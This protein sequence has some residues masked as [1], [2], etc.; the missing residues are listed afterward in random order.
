[1]CVL[2]ANEAQTFDLRAPSED[3]ILGGFGPGLHGLVDVNGGRL[4]GF[5][6]LEV[7]VARTF[8]INSM[9]CSISLRFLN[10]YGLTDPF[11]VDLISETDGTVTWRARLRDLKLF[12]LFPTLALYVRF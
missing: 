9:L 1:M 8:W 3:A 6:R 11:L 7:E 5:Q 10:A 4:P 2:T 12:P